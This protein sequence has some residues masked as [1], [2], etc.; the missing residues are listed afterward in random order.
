M[1]ANITEAGA[2]GMRGTPGCI[3]GRTTPGDT[4]RGR[5]LTGFHRYADFRTIVSIE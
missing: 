1:E 5:L 3:L 2:V 4:I